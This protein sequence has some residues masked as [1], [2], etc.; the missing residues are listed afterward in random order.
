LGTD[1]KEKRTERI[2]LYRE[3]E[4]GRERE[5]EREREWRDRTFR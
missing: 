1:K 4:R 5:R 3:R 2:E